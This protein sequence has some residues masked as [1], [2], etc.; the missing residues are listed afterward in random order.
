M[1][2]AP[3]GDFVEARRFVAQLGAALTASG[4]PVHTV[5]RR[6]EVVAHAY[7][8]R[9]ARISAFPTYFM[10]TMGPGDPVVL[11][12]T[13]PLAA[14]PRL[15]QIAAL[16]TLVDD[17][18]HGE[19]DPADGLERLAVIREL[20]PRFG[21]VVSVAGYALLTLGLC[22]ILH[23]APRDV[24]AA[25]V[26]GAFVGWLRNL[27][28]GHRSFE[29]VLPVAAAFS[30]AAISAIAVEHGLRGAGLAAMVAALVVFLPGAA[31]TTA[32][33]ELAAGQMVSGSSRLVSGAVQLAFLAFGILGGIE[34]VGAPSARVLGASGAPLGPWAPWA[35]VAVFAVGVY[36]AHSARRGSLLALLVVLYAA[37]TVQRLGNG[38]FGSYVSTFLG[39]VALT[40]VAALVARLPD[41][42]PTEASFL[43]GFWL[44]VPGA[45]GLIGLTTFAG[46]A[47]NGAQ[48]LVTTTITIFA[49]AVGVL[50]GT[51]LLEAAAASQRAASAFSRSTTVAAPRRK[52]RR[53]IRRRRRGTPR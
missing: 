10:L 52:I 30:V 33:L 23:P 4:Q 15:D 49:V 24:L 50:C 36:F 20:P 11:E 44:L 35:G 9:T 42:M 29:V 43:P 13:L 47:A 41:A 14:M 7:G 16:E 28:R 3:A 34:I 45:L 40:V 5:Q 21:T 18:E 22:L 25:A 46:D 1:P 12:L 2:A 32:V 31:L 51:L 27:G 26:F 6:L 37:W 8:A 19:V 48:D 53:W 39:A 17:A 38:V